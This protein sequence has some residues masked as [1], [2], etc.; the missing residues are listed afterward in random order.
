MAKLQDSLQSGCDLNGPP[1][2][3]IKEEGAT[4]LQDPS[5]F[6]NDGAQKLKVGAV[7]QSILDRAASA[8]SLAQ[9][10]GRVEEDNVR[11][12]RS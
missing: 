3:V 5:R 2:D 10:E 4:R 8:V 12:V 7:A 1:W 11:Y 9:V 6:V